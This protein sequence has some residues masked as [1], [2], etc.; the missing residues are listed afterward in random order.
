ME[1][2]HECAENEVIFAKTQLGLKWK[3]R[4]QIAIGV[5]FGKV[6]AVEG[7]EVYPTLLEMHNIVTKIVDATEI[8]CHRLG[9]T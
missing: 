9:L 5:A 4:L 3:Y 2:L 8:E 7:K 1:G 6:E